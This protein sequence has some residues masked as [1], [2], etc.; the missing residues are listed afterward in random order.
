MPE[1]KNAL[2]GSGNVAREAREVS[3]M[4]GIVRF[5]APGELIVTSGEANE[6][7]IEA[8]DNLLGLIQ[9]QVENGVLIIA[10]AIEPDV[11][12]Q[13]NH[14]IRYLL[15][16]S[17][18][19]ALTLA[20]PGSIKALGI[21]ADALDVNLSGSGTINL[22]GQAAR[23]TVDIQGGGIYQAGDLQTKSTTI[24]SYGGV[25]ATVWATESLDVACKGVCSIKY[26]GDPEVKK[27]IGVTGTV[28]KLGSK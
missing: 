17:E 7:T 13:I 2:R 25:D 9:T 6:L 18:V 8:E 28:T 14:P 21:Q 15:T 5:E 19:H 1:P 16:V 4:V 26:Y 20:G 27:N 11:T 24:T 12:L 10:M 3:K 22:A 23:Q